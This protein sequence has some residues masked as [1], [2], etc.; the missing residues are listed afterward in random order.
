MLTAMML[1]YTS[2]PIYFLMLVNILIL[3]MGMFVEG[4]AM[5]MIVV[6]LLFTTAVAMGI[7]PIH[8]GFV[9]IVNQAIG[10]ITPPFGTIMFL[11]CSLCKV[12]T[13][14]FLEEAWPY[15]LALIVALLIITYFP[16]LI[17]FLPN[18]LMR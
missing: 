9:L 6:P 4:T 15:I 11:T 17:T 13:I 5:L 14:D 10:G 1:N 8:F 2:N 18:L 7:D 16:P 12:S 3:I